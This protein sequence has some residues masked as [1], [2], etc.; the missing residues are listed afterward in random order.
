MPRLTNRRAQSSNIN[1]SD[2]AWDAKNFI[3]SLDS[4]AKEVPAFNIHG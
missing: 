1:N 4:F 3:R 2:R